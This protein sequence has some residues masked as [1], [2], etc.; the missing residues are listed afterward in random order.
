MG[1][2]HA[3]IVGAD[4]AT[5]V[6]GEQNV[7][8]GDAA[9]LVGGTGNRA[10]GG[11][12]FLGGGAFNTARNDASYS[13]VSGGISNLCAGYCST[14]PG[15]EANQAGGDFSLAA[16]R[17]AQAAHAGAFVWA[18]SV[19]ADL[20]SSTNDEFSV[21]ASGGIRLFSDTNSTSGVTLRPGSGSWSSLSDRPLKQ[22]SSRSTVSRSSIDWRKCPSPPGAIR[23][24]TFPSG[25]WA[26]WLRTL[27]RHSMSAK[28]NNTSAQ[29]MQM[30]SRWRRFRA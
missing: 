19:D 8:F 22:T 20:I 29:S 7:A 16:G 6:G 14:V 21:R 3:N 11:N 25:T 4:F 18:D 30:A 23:A 17:R 27:R 12:S 5:L 28:T 2:G 15:G 26:R 24:R 10:D 13:S 1:G 9:S